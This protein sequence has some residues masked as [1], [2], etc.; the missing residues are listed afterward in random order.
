MQGHC[1]VYS[2]GIRSSR[3]L[4]EWLFKEGSGGGRE[5]DREREKERS[6]ERERERKKREREEGGREEERE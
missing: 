2:H 5:R 4:F 6:R 1:R 3:Y